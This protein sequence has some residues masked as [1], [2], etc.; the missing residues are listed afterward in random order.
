[1]IIGHTRDVARFA[2][3]DHFAAYNGTAPIEFE[4]GGRS[5]HRLSLRGN[6]QLN[7]AIHIVAVTQIRHRH[8]PGRGFY[9]RKLA[10]GKTTKEALR[11]L[12]RRISD[13]VYAPTR[14]DAARRGPGGQAGTT[15][16]SSVA[17]LTPRTAGSSEEP[18]PDH[19]QRYDPAPRTPRAHPTH[20]HAL[21]NK[22]EI[23]RHG[24]TA[25]VARRTV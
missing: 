20:E 9:D 15:L 2:N 7:H 25:S 17:G 10:E 5:V 19:P 11:A 18:L 14:A 6:R 12:K 24:L 23:A 1:M 16:Q 22:E 4:S 3:R 21:D 8:S 13:V